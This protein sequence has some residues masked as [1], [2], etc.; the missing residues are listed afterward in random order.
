MRSKV[1]SALLAVLVFT[2]PAFAR[3]DEHQW[4]GTKGPITTEYFIK[5]HEFRKKEMGIRRLSAASAK[6][7]NEDVGEIA[8]MKANS[9]TLI[10]PNVFDMKGKKITFTRNPQ[11]GFDVKVG[12]GSISG[13][14]GTAIVLT[15]DDSEK[16][17]FTN[18]FN[19]QFYGTTYNSVF[20]NTDGNLTFKQSD[21]ASTARDI[22]RVI[23]GPPRIAP[24]FQDLN[25]QVKGQ[26]LVLQSSTKF[27]VT[28]NEVSEFLDAGSNSN[29]FQLN[30]FKNGNIEF[31]YA[32]KIDTRAAIVGICPGNTSFSNVKLVNYSSISTLAGVKTAVLERFAARQEVDF[33]ALINEFYQTHPQVFDFIVVWTDF[34]ALTGT[35]A[36]AFYSG[37]QNNIK[38]IGQPS[39]NF[40]KAF[41]SSKVQGFLMMDF[42]TKY[43]DDPNKEFLFSN[44]TL[45]VFGQEN[46]HRWLAFPEVSI[47]GQPAN[48]LLGRAESHWNFYMDTDASCMEGNDIRDNADGTFTTIQANETY[49]KLDRYIMGFLPPGAVPATFVVTGNSDV[50]RPPEPGVTIRGTRVNVSLQDLLRAEGARVPNNTASQKT[51]REAFILFTKKS[52]PSQADLTKL[53]KIRTMWAAFWKKHTVNSTIDTTLP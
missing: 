51:F 48:L 22:F 26:V 38:G 4:C 3:T 27:T 43:P 29:T 34:G 28:W 13:N 21:F 50:E 17:N 53:D 47:A 20:L 8:V 14:Q 18:G 42:I 49:S 36:F 31:I 45:E 9:T 44:S 40:T 16:V 39:Y 6:R 12:A 37:I 41:G 52:A 7:N 10:T 25:P 5:N 30:L 35:G 24:F 23:T 15:D 32:S 33:T 2:P 1:L 19:F 11:G 46:G